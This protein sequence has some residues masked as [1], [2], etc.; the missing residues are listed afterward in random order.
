MQAE[1]DHIKKMVLP[2]LREALEAHGISVHVTDLRWGVN[3]ADEPEETREMKVLH[4]CLDAIRRD[5]PYFVGLLGKRYGW[6]PSAERMTRLCESL[7]DDDRM[8]VGDISGKSVT[9]LEMLLGAIGSAKVLPHSFFFIRQDSDYDAIPP[10]FRNLYVDVDADAQIRIN[11]LEARIR[12]VFAAER[13]DDHVL[14]YGFG[15]NADRQ[16]VSGLEEFGELVYQAL[17]KDILADQDSEQDE[18]GFDAERRALLNF[19]GGKLDNFSGR[20]GL[21]E[22]LVHKLLSVDP[23]RPV[24]HNG[25]F[26]TGDS[27]SGKS[28][29]FAKL[30]DLLSEMAA[31]DHKMVILAHAAGVTKDSCS[32]ENMVARWT[33]ELA[34]LPELDYPELDDTHNYTYSAF[35]NLLWQAVYY[36]YRPVIL[37]DSYDS[38]LHAANDYYESDRVAQNLSFIPGNIPFVCTTLPGM[39]ERYVDARPS[40]TLVALDR[41]TIDEANEL[42]DR[43]LATATK[44]L[45]QSVRNSLLSKCHVDGTQAYSSP[46]WLSMA[47]AMLDELG[48]DDFREINRRQ[49][50]RDDL[51][52]NSYLS[53]VVESMPVDVEG[54]FERFIELAAHYFP[55]R[56]VK[57]TLVFSAISE[58]G[59]SE[60]EMELLSGDSWD[61]L[62]F[63]GFA[64]WFR[65]FFRRSPVNKRWELTHDRL[66][67]CLM[68]RYGALASELRDRYINVLAERLETDDPD[69]LDEML[70]QTLK[71]GNVRAFA[72]IAAYIE[73]REGDFPVQKVVQWVPSKITLEQFGDFL[74]TMVNAVMDNDSAMVEISREL[75]Y[76][77]ES[78]TYMSF[79]ADIRRGDCADMLE[80]L[81]DLCTD[82]RLNDGRYEKL[83]M[84]IGLWAAV[85]SLCQQLGFA[86]MNQRNDAVYGRCMPVLRNV[87]D[88]CGARTIGYWPARQ[89]MTIAYHYFNIPWQDLVELDPDER[90]AILDAEDGAY[91]KEMK[92]RMEGLLDIA[93]VLVGV[94]ERLREWVVRDLE[95]AVKDR[96]GTKFLWSDVPA[97]ERRIAAIKDRMPEPEPEPEP[98]SEPET[99]SVVHGCNDEVEP[100]APVDAVVMSPLDEARVKFN[101]CVGRFIGG[102]GHDDYDE[103]TGAAVA[104]ADMLVADGE[105]ANAADLI[106]RMAIMYAIHLENIPYYYQPKRY[107]G[108]TY[109]HDSRGGYYHDYK[110]NPYDTASLMIEWLDGHGH[111][112]KAVCLRERFNP[113]MTTFYKFYTKQG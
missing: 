37:I 108:Y 10:E 38:F 101:K 24:A 58:G 92:R 66:K 100:V 52:I 72:R 54:L 102:T 110:M 41:F 94:S 39:V 63:A 77:V 15:W 75:R 3:T 86:R 33:E 78:F 4:V 45:P 60:P 7:H 36:G 16:C 27:G 112:D 67:A 90:Y 30:Y 51:K 89:L 56:L 84:F 57:V 53:Q 93:D 87:I 44:E 99:A 18:C 32:V 12:S 50:D 83:S 104:L 98:E 74:A 48:D 14:S 9:E 82:A 107:D 17:L 97:F 61:E 26:L 1:R 109:H 49:F 73:E 59:L 23:L 47:I 79:Q 106:E 8:L 105:P 21:V 34:V 111:R 11:R 20:K 19:T 13:L 2:R 91:Y 55:E 64:K 25:Y 81:L 69:V 96:N 43:S 85:D 103:L 71:Q 40:Y 80:R 113:L 62:Q 29:V 68:D 6:V 35:N 42:V 28:A 95:R 65:P 88:R 22:D 5:R 46:F 31:H 76:F 70:F